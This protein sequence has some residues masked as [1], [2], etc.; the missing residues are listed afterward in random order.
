MLY[1]YGVWQLG[2]FQSPASPPSACAAVLNY[3]NSAIKT[4]TVTLLYTTSRTW[5]QPVSERTTLAPS[6]R[7][8]NGG[9]GS[10]SNSNDV[11]S[12]DHNDDDVTL[13]R[14][15]SLDVVWRHWTSWRCDVVRSPTPCHQA[16]TSPWDCYC[17]GWSQSTRCDLEILTKVKARR[18]LDT[19]QRSRWVAG[20]QA[21]TDG[22]CRWA[23]WWP[24]RR[25][26][27]SFD[28]RAPKTRCVVA[29]SR[30]W[31]CPGTT[32]SRSRWRAEPR[33]VVTWCHVISRWRR[34][35]DFMTH[36]GLP[37]T[38]CHV[39]SSRCI[40]VTPTLSRTI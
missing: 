20:H 6:V 24:R 16:T 10:A 15:A 33:D 5:N 29:T 4:V 25:C 30:T 1:G 39:T 27:G 17:P 34:P 14:L 40:V 23:R 21:T 28:S 22:C 2:A 8:E 26:R 18:D 35:V 9:E 7:W 31:S 32:L 38:C 12:V 13:L 3:C 11:T 19:D 37:R 36:V